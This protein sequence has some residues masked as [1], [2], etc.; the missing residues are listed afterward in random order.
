MLN[1]LSIIRYFEFNYVCSQ[2]A[3]INEIEIL[4]ISFPNL[5]G[6]FPYNN[7]DYKYVY[8]N[9]N[10]KDLSNVITLSEKLNIK[11]YFDEKQ[12]VKRLGYKK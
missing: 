3:I 2:I 8:T 12:D 1:P 9:P 4:D 6:F 11:N 7:I 10:I 5:F